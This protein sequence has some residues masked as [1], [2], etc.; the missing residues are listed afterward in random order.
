MDCELET[1]WSSTLE[2]FFDAFKERKNRSSEDIWKLGVSY[3]YC[4]SCNE[5]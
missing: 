5:C 4:Q 3:L 2:E 1:S